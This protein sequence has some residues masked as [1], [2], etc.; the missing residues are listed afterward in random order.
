MEIKNI[1]TTTLTTN[2][3]KFCVSRKNLDQKTI[4]SYT[5][6]LRQYFEFTMESAIEWTNK[7]SI[8]QYIDL[9]HFKYKPKSVKRKIAS[10]KAFFHYLEI[11]ELIGI[12]PFHRIQIKYKEPF[13]LPKTI[14]INNIEQIIR[15]AYLQLTKAKTD[16]TKKVALRNALILELLFATGM[17]I[18]ELCTLTTEQIDFNDYIIKIYGKGSKERLIQICNQNVQELL[19]KYN[20]SFKF[21]IANNRF[22]FI[23]RLGNRLSEQ[24]VRNMINSYVIGAEVP[25]HITPHMFR[26]SFATLLLEEDVDIRYIQ[27][28]LGHSSITTTQIYTHTSINKQKN[29]LSAKHPRNKL[30]IGI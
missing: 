2:Y 4:K 13:I 20:Q 3:L 16:Y 21:G 17:R 11:E 1:Q 23:N 25:L 22:F 12:N 10:L 30:E 26:H 5:I 14:P 19:K 27:Q 18:S 15:F 24:S 8:E 9:L 28:M 29:I 7:K 6:D